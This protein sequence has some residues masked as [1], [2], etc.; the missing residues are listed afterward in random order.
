[1]SKVIAIANQK[2]DVGKTTTTVNLGKQG[3][4]FKE[5][6]S[7]EVDE[8]VAEMVVD[9]KEEKFVNIRQNEVMKTQTNTEGIAVF[10]PVLEDRTNDNGIAEV[11]RY[12]ITVKHTLGETTKPIKNLLIKFIPA[13]YDKDGNTKAEQEI[14]VATDGTVDIPKGGKTQISVFDNEIGQYVQNIKIRFITEIKKPMEISKEEPKEETQPRKKRIRD[15]LLEL[16]KNIK[17]KLWRY[18]HNEKE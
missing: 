13:V 7:F 9:L 10:Y 17:F 11:S 1:M 5:N 3:E 16:F 12:L 4:Y 2:G 15:Y 14:T 6:L 8:D 18:I